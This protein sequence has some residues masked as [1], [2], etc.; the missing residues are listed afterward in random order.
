VGITGLKTHLHST[1]SEKPSI[2]GW[3]LLWTPEAGCLCFVTTNQTPFQEMTLMLPKESPSNGCAT[4][5][6]AKPP[7]EPLLPR[8]KPWQG[9]QLGYKTNWAEAHPSWV[10]QLLHT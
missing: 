9:Y 4:L 6:A 8:A 2:K 5:G 3:G 1:S 7:K 10:L